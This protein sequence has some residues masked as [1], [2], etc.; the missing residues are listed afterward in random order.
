[1]NAMIE[2]RP[3]VNRSGVCGGVVRNFIR[4]LK[5]SCADVAKTSAKVT[6]AAAVSL[7]SLTSLLTP[8][9]LLAQGTPIS[10]TAQVTLSPSVTSLNM[11][12]SVQATLR[13]DLTGV[14]GRDSSGASTPA[15]LGGYQVAVSFDRTMLQ[16]TGATGGTSSGYTGTPTFTTPSTANTNG[17]VTVTASQADAAAPTGLVV[18]AVLNFT[19]I[20]PGTSNLNPTPGSL[21]TA[22]QLGAAGSPALIPGNGTPIS[23]TVIPS[24]NPVPAV[25]S[26][27]PNSTTAGAGG[28]TLTVNGSNFVNGSV[29]RWAG[30]DRPTTFLSANQLTAQISAADVASAGTIGVTVFNPGPGGGLSNAVNFTV[31]AAGN[32]IPGILNLNPSSTTAG[33]AGFT[34]TV[35]GSNF[36]NGS[37]VR[38]NGSDR[39]TTFVS[40]NQLTATITAADIA[41]PGS[42]PVTVFNP[43]PGGGTSNAVF[44]TVNPVSG[45]PVPSITSINPTTAVAGGAAFT[46]TVNGA[47]FVSGAVVR[48]NGSDRA[49]TFVSATQLTAS[50]P[51]SDIANPV[52]ASVTVFNPSPGGGSSNAVSFTVSAVGNPV[53]VI[54]A[55]TP[56]SVPAG[57]ANFTLF[58]D[59]SNF[60]NGSTIYWA[61][62]AR[63]TSFVSSTRLRWDVPASLVTTP[64]TVPVTVLSP[65]PGGG[66]S[67]TVNFVIT[68]PGN[69]VPAIT[70]ISP[71]T[72]TPGSAAFTLTVNGSNL[73]STSV[74][75]WNGVDRPTTFVNANRVTAAIP[76]SDVAAVGSF[77]VS[78]F[79]PGPAGGISNV[80][81]FSVTAAGGNPVPSIIGLSPGSTLAGGAAF[82]LTVN[83]ANF[84]AVAVAQ[85][86]GSPRPTTFVSS[87]QLQVSI[88]ASDIASAGT[89]TVN[90]SNPGPGG[91]LSNGVGFLVTGGNANP[92]ATIAGLSPASATIGS[93][94]FTLTV[95]GINF[96][97]G[98]VVRWN[99]SDRPT[100]F[101]SPNQLTA[102]ISAADVAAGGTVFVSVFN[103]PPGGGLSNTFPF[104][105][106]S[107]PPSP[108]PSISSLSPDS[109][110]VGEGSFT[111]RVNGSNFVPSSVVRWNGADR[112]TTYISPTR[113]NAS[114]SASDVASLGSAQVRVFNPPPG[115][116]LSNAVTF[117][118]NT[119]NP[120]PRITRLTPSIVVAGSGSFILV[121]EG[122]GFVDS[123]ARLNGSQL[124]VISVTPTRITVRVPDVDI[125]EPGTYLVTVFNPPP[126]GGV[127]DPFPLVV[128]SGG[129]VLNA[130]FDFLPVAPVAGQTVTFND[131]SAGAAATWRWNFGDG[132]TASSRNVTHVFSQAGTYTVTLTISNGT[133]SHTKTRTV[134]VAPAPNVRLSSVLPV[135][136]QIPGLGE[137]FWRSEV[138]FHNLGTE[139]AIIDLVF[140]PAAGGSLQSRQIILPA[141]STK[142]YAS[143]LPDLFGVNSGSG[144]LMIDARGAT[145]TP[146]IRVSSRTFTTNL[147]GTY[148]Q[149]VPEVGSLLPATSYI[150]GIESNPNYRT[151]IG[152]LNKGTTFSNTVLTLYDSTGATLGST[153]VSVPARGFQQ[154]DL[155][156]LFPLLRGQGESGLSMKVQSPADGSVAAYASVIDNRTQD[157]VF[158]PAIPAPVSR[159]LV[160]PA[161]ARI[162][163]AEGTFWRS[164]V[165]FFNPTSNTMTLV[166]HLVYSDV[167]NR[168]ARGR[169]ITLHP[170]RSETILDVVDWLEAGNSR[171]ALQ[172]AS[173]GGSGG[174]PVV[175]S[176]TYTTRPSDGGTFGQFVG[177]VET[178]QFTSETTV[179]GLRSDAFYR[180]NIGIVSSSNEEVRVQLTLHDASSQ[181]GTAVVTVLPKS[182]RQLPLAGLFPSVNT[183]TLGSFTVRAA[184][185]AGQSLYLYGSTI[186]NR[187]GDPIFVSGR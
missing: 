62:V 145:R 36:V 179:T 156:S 32:P 164:D 56:A 163:G 38:W 128:S 63:P 43:A 177:A 74:V 118:I 14:T 88:P 37:I 41:S 50:I 5:L 79:N 26:I 15:V 70:S 83:G 52:T 151:N 8:D 129:S 114:I 122:T 170:G 64:G 119:G 47:N 159:E 187:S 104:V 146:Q 31:N 61:G 153:A 180:T 120:V 105:V 143:I 133:T 150:T 184:T 167:D 100:T 44:F 158:I 11:G 162:P 168:G 80:L 67:N 98:A 139:S 24:G 134:V 116:G 178:N 71:T 148:G 160:V 84:V 12:S 176:R 157:P 141:G 75:R 109:A 127:S 13:I 22:F 53:P 3:G 89:F 10:G 106:G 60:V 96:V 171:G 152:F 135:T 45:N 166:V 46:L 91:G 29:V 6:R 17:S 49:T 181:I 111:L 33:G 48:W 123:G 73:V 132:S 40:V 30:S 161:V 78:V 59:G 86:N 7:I 140:L 155:L 130:D 186:D 183:A 121:I 23:I 42:V 124:P 68:A 102:S 92:V 172:I 93:P 103:P 51:A 82:T 99:G 169:V 9:S 90:V 39:P 16:F 131:R 137:T 4:T 175:S 18:V 35:N 27:S 110:G 107:V 77:G 19:A 165:T 173:S 55:L 58:V 174:G 115:G 21:S 112:P 25:T 136:T 81:N 54:T 1:M 65:T 182:H 154:L 97:P 142:T 66:F 147:Q 117:V 76:A 28:F 85:W 87:T 95:T 138:T 94:A 69:P 34:I 113:V 72:T 2:V 185:Q 125:L 126:G 101:V 108:V 57:N 144:G 20:G 149:F